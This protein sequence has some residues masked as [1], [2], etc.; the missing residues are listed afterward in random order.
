MAGSKISAGKIIGFVF[1]GLF[2]LFIFSSACF[3]SGLFTG[4]FSLALK[5]LPI[6]AMPDSIYVIRMEGIISGTEAAGLFSTSAVTPEYMI[7]QF[8]AAEKNPNV[9]ALLIR[10]NS[11]GGSAAASREIFEEL[12]KIKKPVV[13]SVSDVCASGAY[14]ISCA[15]DKI[16]A[17]RSSS[18]GS[19]G[20]I[21]QIPNLEELYKKLGIKYTTIKQGQYKDSGSTDRPLTPEEEK[22]FRQQT[23]KIYE[24]FIADVVETRG[25][26]VEKVEEIANGWVYLG[27]EA[28]ELGLI[29]EIGTYKDAEKIAA[30]LGGIK[31]EP[32]IVYGKKYSIFDA[33]LQSFLYKI[34]NLAFKI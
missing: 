9:K 23:F 2:V 6:S 21:M 25:L 27:T 1:L 8:I 26:T 10:V 34:I 33:F 24:Q 31:G 14:Y 11:G 7:E 5:G 13:I 19:I 32:N 22:L 12:K 3:V 30:R 17:N 18:V 4:G 20:V 29:D 15:A 28:K 16:V